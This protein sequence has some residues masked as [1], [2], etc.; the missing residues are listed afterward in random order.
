MGS[1]TTGTPAASDLATVPCPA[2]VTTAE[3]CR[4]TSPC[5][6]A[7]TPAWSVNVELSETSTELARAL[8]DLP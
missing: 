5:G 6:R 1:A 7:R 4:K 2:C 8:P 3:A